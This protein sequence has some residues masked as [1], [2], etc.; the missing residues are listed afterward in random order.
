MRLPASRSSANA[1]ARSLARGLLV[2][3]LAASLGA[4]GLFQG[5]KA[6]KLDNPLQ[7]TPESKPP[8]ANPKAGSQAHLAL[9]VSYFQSGDLADAQLEAQ[10]AAKLD[11]SN[12][13]AV[14]MLGIVAM[15]QKNYPEAETQFSRALSIAPGNAD[16]MNNLAGVYCRTQRVDQGVQLY[17]KALATPGYA[18]TTGTLINASICLQ[19]KPDYA[20]AEAF[21]RSARRSDPNDTTAIYQLASLLLRDGKPQQALVELDALHRRQAPDAAALWLQFLSARASGDSVAAERASALLQ[22]QFPRSAQTDQLLRRDYTPPNPT[23]D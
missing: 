23:Q 15:A 11:G 17:G 22:S 8:K 10:T 14:S 20:A 18:K 2:A 13:E 16:A 5:Y 21:L 6:P 4:C 19:R 1:F 7:P 3:G 12:A 9:A